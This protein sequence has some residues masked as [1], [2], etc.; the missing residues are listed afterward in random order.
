MYASER[1]LR[2][3]ILSIDPRTAGSGSG[4]GRT[5]GSTSASS[6]GDTSM[7][8]FSGR[9]AFADQGRSHS[10]ATRTGRPGRAIRLPREVAS[11]STARGG[12]P[13]LDMT[14]AAIAS[15]A[16]DA[17]RVYWR[18]STFARTGAK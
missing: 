3:T 1:T 4:I 8:V 9:A 5:T 15:G 13:A 10:G 7:R 18:A 14:P 6:D 2:I 17:A 11:I 12:F 16:S